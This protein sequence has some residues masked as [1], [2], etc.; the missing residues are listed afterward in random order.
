MLAGDARDTCIVSWLEGSVDQA[1]CS[2]AL[3][4]P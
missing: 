1:A 3:A 4:M 2:R